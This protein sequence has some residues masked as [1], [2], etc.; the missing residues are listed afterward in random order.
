M[1][2]DFVWNFHLWLYVV[3]IT[4][5]YTAP[6]VD[7]T[8]FKHSTIINLLSPQKRNRY[9]EEAETQRS[10]VTG[11]KPYRQQMAEPTNE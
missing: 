7:E 10:K 6:S 3:T 11:S 2:F 5:T 8:L 9:Y 1:E 4:Y